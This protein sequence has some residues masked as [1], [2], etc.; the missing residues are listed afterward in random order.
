VRKIDNGR[1]FRIIDA[2][3]NRTKE[4]LRVCEDVA[5]FIFDNRKVTAEYKK[6]RH[7]LATLAK[8]CGKNTKSLIVYREIEKDVGRRSTSLEFRR[9]SARDIFYANSQRVKESIRVLEEFTKLT[10]P[11]RAEGFKR[12]RYRIYAL[13]KDIVKKF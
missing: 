9:E 10:N 6:V 7:A 8:A 4:G 2:N 11:K 5:R 1:I 3:L 12:L 13:E